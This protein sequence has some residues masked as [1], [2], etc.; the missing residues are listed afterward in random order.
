MYLHD[1]I[2]TDKRNPTVNA[3]GKIYGSPEESSDD[4]P[5][6]DPVKQHHVVHQATP[7]SI[8]Q[9]PSAKDDPMA[10]SVFWGD[11]PIWD[12]HTSIHNPMMDEKGRVWFT[13]RIRR[14][15]NPDYCKDGSDLPSAQVAPLKE[16]A[17]Q[18]SMYDPKTGKVDDDRYVLQHASSRLHARRKALVQR[19]AALQRRRRLARRQEVRGDRRRDEVAGLDADRSPTSPAPASARPLSRPIKPIDPARTS[20]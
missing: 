20:G 13:A 16:S 10:P 14:A 2:S 18:L 7:I 1:E 4:V 11:E 19:R 8:P 3:N 17:R 12:G 6:L 5:V 15:P 9:T